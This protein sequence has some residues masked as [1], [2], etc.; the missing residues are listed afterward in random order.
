MG[1]NQSVQ[2]C[3]AVIYNL[4]YTET[5]ANNVDLKNLLGGAQPKWN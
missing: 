2:R 1:S 5:H 3:N 4:K